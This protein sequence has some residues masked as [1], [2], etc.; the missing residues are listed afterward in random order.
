M[1]LIALPRREATS[2]SRVQAE[3]AQL[4][5]SLPRGRYEVMYVTP[6][7]TSMHGLRQRVTGNLLTSATSRCYIDS[8][9][10]TT[11]IGVESES[12]KSSDTVGATPQLHHFP[13]CESVRL[14]VR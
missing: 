2:L 14:S 13:G 6:R 9:V 11:L 3:E 4:G 5:T 8:V 12:T 10:L 1:L 7:A